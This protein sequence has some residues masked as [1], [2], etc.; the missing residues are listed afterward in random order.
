MQDKSCIFIER[1]YDAGMPA[2]RPAKTKRPSFGERLA[3]IRQ[4]TGLTQLQLAEKLGTS[5]RM[6]TYWEREG[7]A[8]RPDQLAALANTLGVTTD[9]L[10]G[11]D[12][13]KKRGGGP[14]GRA[15]R[16]FEA[17]SQLPRHQQE[18]IIDVVDALI[19]QHNGYRQ[20]A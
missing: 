4:E 16:L 18:K 12:T 19:A 13:P 6:I 15:K 20:T 11:K 7:V 10:V 8:L 3:Q 2:G 5:Q 17:V 14:T 9:F 1:G